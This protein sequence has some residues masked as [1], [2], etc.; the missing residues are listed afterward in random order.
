MSGREQGGL[1]MPQVQIGQIMTMTGIILLLYTF[2][3]YPSCAKKLGT[4]L[5]FRTGQVR[6]SREKCLQYID[7][8]LAS[9]S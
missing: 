5:G 2:F 4:K 7:F 3:L 8:N 1:D 6:K 9:Y